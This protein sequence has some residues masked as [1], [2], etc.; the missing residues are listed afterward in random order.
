MIHLDTNYLIPAMA[1]GTPQDSRLR[2]WLA[3]GKSVNVSTV[4][5]A[6]FHCGPLTAA[7]SHLA[8]AL[9]PAPEP[10]LAADSVR[11]AELFNQTG[12]RRGSLADCMIAA[13]AIRAGATLATEN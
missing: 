13:V 8:T 5:W 2:T 11:A 1:P 6:E 10:L 4:A 7:Q 12:R 3:G 9:F